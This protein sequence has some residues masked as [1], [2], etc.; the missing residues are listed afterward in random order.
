M[1]WSHGEEMDLEI[2]VKFEF[3]WRRKAWVR[4]RKGGADGLE[5]F[6]WIWF[7]M[8]KKGMGQTAGERKRTCEKERKKESEERD[9]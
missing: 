9:R 1:R 8:E 4:G 5:A 7:Q 6:D 3:K 2:W